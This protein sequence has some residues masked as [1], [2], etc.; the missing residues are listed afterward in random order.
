MDYPPLLPFLGEEMK[1]LSTL[2]EWLLE[3]RDVKE[4]LKETVKERMKEYNLLFTDRGL[5]DVGLEIQGEVLEKQ[6]FGCQR[7]N[8]L[9]ILSV[10]L[11]EDLRDS[12]KGIEIEPFTLIKMKSNPNEHGYE[13]GKPYLFIGRIPERGRDIASGPAGGLGNNIPTRLD[14]LEMVTEE[15]FESF[16]KVF[17]I[18]R[19]LKGVANG[20]E[21]S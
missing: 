10:V 17:Q 18:G 13:L 5:S 2:V 14:S 12:R 20:F 8:T 19:F 11:K 4:V 16:F 15:D 1:N 7:G 6:L 9:R 21:G 3:G